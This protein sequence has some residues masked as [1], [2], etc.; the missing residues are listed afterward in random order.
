MSLPVE[1]V[2]LFSVLGHTFRDHWFG[3]TT[4][5]FNFYFNLHAVNVFYVKI[6]RQFF[7]EMQ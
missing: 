2:D 7:F 5:N 1:Y 3:K 4:C 6:K